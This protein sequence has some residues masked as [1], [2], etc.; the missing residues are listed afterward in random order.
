[1]NNIRL[2]AKWEL[3]E[4]LPI[5]AAIIHGRRTLILKS[6]CFPAAVGWFT[7]EMEE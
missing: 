6:Y 7:V 4:V 1:M 3:F 2:C 5:C